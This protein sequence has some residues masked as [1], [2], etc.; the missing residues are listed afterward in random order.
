MVLLLND[1]RLNYSSICCMLTRLSPFALSGKAVTGREL[2]E[3]RRGVPPL[4]NN[5]ANRRMPCDSAIE[6]IV[7]PIADPCALIRS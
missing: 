4:V 1:V 6:A 7:L 3:A 5:L 2:E